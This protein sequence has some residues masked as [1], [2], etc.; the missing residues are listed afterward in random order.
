MQKDQGRGCADGQ[1]QHINSTKQ[2]ASLPTVAIESLL[3][4]CM[5]DA[6]EGGDVATMDMDELVHIRL[7]GTMADLVVHLSP[8][9][10]N[11]FVIHNH[12]KTCYT[13]S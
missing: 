6:K 4:S 5:I 2:E 12:E 8:E 13:C 10:Y 7:E 3:L 11:K 1:K 9:T